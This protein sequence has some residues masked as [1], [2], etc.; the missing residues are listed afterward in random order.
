MSCSFCRDSC[1][2]FA[3]T[4]TE[5]FRGDSRRAPT[6]LETIVDDFC[7]SRTVTQSSLTDVGP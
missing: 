7:T 6:L 1:F 4:A 2:K 5:S 3:G